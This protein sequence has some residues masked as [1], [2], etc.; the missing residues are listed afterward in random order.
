[1]LCNNKHKS[2]DIIFLGD[3]IIKKNEIDNKIKEI[4]EKIDK[5]NNNIKE[6]IEIINEDREI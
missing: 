4:K 2:H 3:I 5:F 6:I 1:M